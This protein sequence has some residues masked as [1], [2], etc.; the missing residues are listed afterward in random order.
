[1][2]EQ[3]DAAQNTFEVAKVTD[4]EAVSQQPL[5]EE[6]LKN[7]RQFIFRETFTRDASNSNLK[8]LIQQP[9]D[10]SNAIRIIGRLFEAN[11]AIEGT[12]SFN[13]ETNTQGTEFSYAN[14]KV[15]DPMP[16]VSNIRVEYDGDYDKTAGSADVIPIEVLET[17]RGNNRRAMASSRAAFRLTPG[18][19]VLYDVDVQSDGTDMVVEFIVSEQ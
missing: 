14:A 1:M 18:T 13:V 11:K 17:G 2:P 6:S 4:D 9:S 19:N 5:G 15:Q 10:A 7:G 8:V 3:E 12:L 16:T